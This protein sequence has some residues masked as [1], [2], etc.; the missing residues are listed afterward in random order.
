MLS[1]NSYNLYVLATSQEEVKEIGVRLNQ[2]SETLRDRLAER[3]GVR[4]DGLS[5]I[6]DFRIVRNVA[7]MEA[8]VRR[9][10]LAIE[11]RYRGTLAKHLVEISATF[12]RA[13]FL[14]QSEGSSFSRKEVLRA[15]QR[16]QVIHA[17]HQQ[18]HPAAWT[19]LDIFTPFRAEHSANLPFGSLWRPWL[20][21]LAAS[22]K[23]LRTNS[24]SASDAQKRRER[25]V[26]RNSR[27]FV[28]HR[29]RSLSK[30]P[31]LAE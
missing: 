26:Q 3:L 1:C 23:Q 20:D 5:E 24:D 19:V 29:P 2:P 28:A 15:G 9:F 10:R 21:D 18:V 4:V 14:L 17:R 22:L 12:P 8:S 31:N 25:I 6:F 16:V 13:A 27:P 7:T 11:D 30:E